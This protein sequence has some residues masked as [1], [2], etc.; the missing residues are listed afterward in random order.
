MLAEEQA[1]AA[2]AKEQ[3]EEENRSKMPP[4]KPS[5]SIGPNATV[6]KLGSGGPPRAGGLVLKTPSDKP[7]LVAKAS[8]P[9]PVRSPWAPLPPVDKVP[10]VSMNP[11]NQ[12]PSTRLQQNDPYIS[13]ASPVPSSAAMEIA[14]DSFTRTR[15]DAQNGNHGQLYNSQS[16]QYEQVNA[17]RRGSMRKEQN[18][19]PP[20]LLQRPSHNEQNG[21]A[22]PSAA[23]QTNRA[24]NQQDAAVWN[25]R[26]SSTV[27]GDSGPHGRRASMKNSEIPRIPLELLQQRRESQPLQSPSTPSH[28]QGRPSQH[29]NSLS[30]VQT[31]QHASQPSASVSIQQYGDGSSVTA[32]P[33]QSKALPTNISSVPHPAN[34]VAAQ[35]QLMREKL[36]LARKR[37][38][39]EEAKEGAERKERIRLKM[40]ELGMPPLVEKKEPEKVL[41]EKKTPETKEV[42]KNKADANEASAK[43]PQVDKT[44]DQNRAPHE[45]PAAM[46][47]S[48]PKPPVLDASGAPKQYGLMK[49]HG[50]PLSNGVPSIKD[51]SPDNRLKPIVSGQH[52]TPSIEDPAPIVPDQIIQ[53][54]VTPPTINGDTPS[55]HSEPSVPESPNTRNQDIFKGSRQQAWKSVQNEAD[56]YTGW[57]NPGMTTHSSPVA[58]LWGPPSS[59]KSLGNGTFDRSVQRPQSRQPPYQENYLPPPPQPIGPPRHLQRH[60]ES[61]ESLRGSDLMSSTPLA[62]DSQTIPTFPASEATAPSSGNRGITASQRIGSEKSVSPPQS[63]LIHQKNPQMNREM[64]RGQDQ[65]RSTL[66]A[67]NNFHIT[68]AR[69][70][71]EK[72]RQVAQEDAARLAE[73]ARTGIR[74]EVQ[75]PTMNETWRQIKTGEQAGSRQVVDV[76]KNVHNALPSQQVNGGS[77]SSLFAPTTMSTAI[78]AS[79]ESR[80]FPGSGQSV[81]TQ[82]SR[83]ASYTMGYDRPASPP[84]PDSTNHP[85]YVRDQERPLVNLPISKPKPIVKLPLARAT[86]VNSPVMANVQVVPLRAVSQPLV[87]NP[88]WQDR[89]NG[90]LGVKKPSPDKKFAH[91]AD[92]SATK[93]PLEV[94]TV[95]PSAAVSLPPQ[96]ELADQTDLG[97]KITKAIEDEEALFENREFGSLPTVNIPRKV[98]E[99]VQSSVQSAMTSKNQ[100]SR[101]GR[102]KEVDAESIKNLEEK[103]QHNANGIVI[104]VKVIGMGERKSKNM[105]RQKIHNPNV[106]AVQRNRHVSVGS[107]HGK[108]IKAR[109]GSGNYGPPKPAQNGIQRNSISNGGNPQQ[110]NHFGKQNSNWSSNQ[111][112]ANAVQ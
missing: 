38:K 104:F 18:F 111:R 57:N 13:D 69:E 82:Q 90:L 54:K 11:P 4:P 27:S 52:N 83:A 53:Q 2:A 41:I 65:A 68:S 22:E 93:L 28:I 31:S 34:D 62:E 37:K 84:P 32:S 47:R 92:F 91:V 105:P 20:S 24:G 107:K 17:P 5:T 86:P 14:A 44:H 15:R 35:K 66:A 75:L 49:V 76:S 60:R 99:A 101:L 109:E 58:N 74:H 50:P 94:T 85:A 51:R 61:P 21:P 96:E 1:A 3:Q 73:E 59:F 48:P 40:E 108:V 100:Y 7:T 78:G 70:D 55:R 56:T 25:R 10:P 23:F 67:W 97:E 36:E 9:A 81:Q 88:S 43:V 87:N 95:Q 19:R 77:Q 64:A 6:L 89:F 12:P 103:E 110:R 29:E 72:R 80:F 79:R 112:V 8:A 26:T 33:Q 45:V 102:F 16:G 63:S 30:Q 106:Q 98:S 42:E 71:D 46:P 39:E